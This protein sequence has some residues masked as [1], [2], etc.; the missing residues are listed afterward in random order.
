MTQGGWGRDNQSSLENGP[1]YM[2]AP[3]IEV[4]HPPCPLSPVPPCLRR[5]SDPGT[6]G[7]L[8]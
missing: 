5:W 3:G 4:W 6:L 1:G 7:Y 8:L 2:I